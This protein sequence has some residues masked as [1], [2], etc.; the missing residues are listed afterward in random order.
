MKHVQREGKLKRKLTADTAA[1]GVWSTQS[2]YYDF[3]DVAHLD[4]MSGEG[5]LVRMPGAETCGEHWEKC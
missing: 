3:Q 4:C 1:V 2:L 5:C